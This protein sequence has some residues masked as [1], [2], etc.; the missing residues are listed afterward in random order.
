[1]RHLAILAALTA[2]GLLAACEPVPAPVQPAEPAIPPAECGATGFK[3]LIGQPRDVLTQM[4]FPLNTRVIGPNDMVTADFRPERL[5]I[6]YGPNGRI[7]KVSC[8]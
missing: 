3:G 7:D 4:N 1:M 8:Y 2:S 6:E 5:N